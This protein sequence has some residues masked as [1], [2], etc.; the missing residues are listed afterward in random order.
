MK[1]DPGSSL[2]K[3]IIVA[4]VAVILLIPLQLLRNLVT[5]HTRMREHAVQQVAQNWKKQQLLNKPVLAIPV[6]VT[7]QFERSTT[8]DWYV[9]PDSLKIE[10]EVTVLDERRTVGIYE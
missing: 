4:R 3:A 10:A 1:L 6:T 2:T 8:R 9:L 5:E 7:D